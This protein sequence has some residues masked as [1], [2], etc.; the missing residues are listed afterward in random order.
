MYNWKLICNDITMSLSWDVIGWV[1]NQDRKYFYIKLK[2]DW[3]N[4]NM[5]RLGSNLVI[6]YKRFVTV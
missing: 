3:F 5:L 1:Y 2:A 6:R 4:G